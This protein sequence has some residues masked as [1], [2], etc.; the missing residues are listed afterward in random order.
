MTRT[1]EL[2]KHLKFIQV[3]REAVTASMKCVCL[4]DRVEVEQIESLLLDRIGFLEELLERRG[5]AA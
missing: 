2:Q 5:V 4:D 1:D 3:A